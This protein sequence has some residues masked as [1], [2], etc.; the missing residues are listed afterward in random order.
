MESMG[1]KHGQMMGRN[2]DAKNPIN[3]KKPLDQLRTKPNYGALLIGVLNVASGKLTTNNHP[4][5]PPVLV[6]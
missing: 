2:Q 4:N 3:P 6:S 5:K 1:L